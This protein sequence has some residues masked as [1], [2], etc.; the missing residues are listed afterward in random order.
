[1]KKSVCIIVM[2]ALTTVLGLILISIDIM[3]LELESQICIWNICF[4]LSLYY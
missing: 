4:T 2:S 1:M 3:F